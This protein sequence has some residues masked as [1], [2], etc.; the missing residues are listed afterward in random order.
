MSRAVCKSCDA[1]NYWHAQR[2]MKLKDMKC[3]VCGGD[4]E[5]YNEKKHANGDGERK[6]TSAVWK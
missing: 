1:L 5:A 2:G 4:L 3:A 6:I